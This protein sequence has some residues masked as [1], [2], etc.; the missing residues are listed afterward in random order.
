[1][2][3]PLFLAEAEK[4]GM[5]ISPVSGEE[6]QKVADSIANTEPAVLARAKAILEN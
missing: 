1:M 5:D 2:K 6:S 3:D 4:A